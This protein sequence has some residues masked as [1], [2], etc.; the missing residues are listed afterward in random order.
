MVIL[1]IET[2]SEFYASLDL[3]ILESV[4]KVAVGKPSV[5]KICCGHTTGSDAPSF[6]I[7]PAQEAEDR[8]DVNF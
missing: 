6:Y 3:L 4:C 7:V 5:V 1:L 2:M 8:T